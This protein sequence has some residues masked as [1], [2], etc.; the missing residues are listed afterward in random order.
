MRGGCWRRMKARNGLRQGLLRPARSA[1]V[2]DMWRCE[3]GWRVARLASNGCGGEIEVCRAL[4]ESDFD[5][6][7]LSLSQAR[8]HCVWVVQLG[9]QVSCCTATEGREPVRHADP[10]HR[11]SRG[12]AL[13]SHERATARSALQ[14]R[15]Q[16]SALRAHHGHGRPNQAC[17][18]EWAGA[19]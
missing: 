5:L 11:E 6:L 8:L 1:L 2:M 16:R 12:D 10:F 15:P 19:H 4:L 18:G 13:C 9:Q 17:R 7:H 14:P 3:D